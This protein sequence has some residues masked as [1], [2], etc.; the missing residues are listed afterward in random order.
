M[1]VCVQW[2]IPISCIL[3]ISVNEDPDRPSTTISFSPR[4][5]FEASL[6]VAAHTGERQERFKQDE[7]KVRQNVWA[8]RSVKDRDA[9]V[10]HIAT[11]F[12][13]VMGHSLGIVTV[14]KSGKE[15]VGRKQLSLQE[16]QAKLLEEE[17]QAAERENAASGGA[18]YAG[19][20]REGLLEK[21]GSKAT[22][23]WKTRFV[24]LFDNRIEYYRKRGDKKPRGTI[25]VSR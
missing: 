7:N 22:S 24:V 21:Q 8:F 19:C 9:A 20:I 5:A 15:I 14:D 18:Y 25:T 4:K 13:D 23:A 1:Y 12:H 17:E 10:S 16:H 6:T 11:L 3:S 2:A